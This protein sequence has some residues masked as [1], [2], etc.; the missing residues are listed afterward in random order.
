MAKRYD[1]IV[2]QMAKHLFVDKGMSQRD[3]TLHLRERYPEQC[4]RLS[5][6]MVGQWVREHHWKELRATLSIS[7][8]EALANA[9]K[10]FIAH[11]QDYLGLKETEPEKFRSDRNSYADF[12]NKMLKDIA[13]LQHMEADPILVYRSLAKVADHYA[14]KDSALAAQLMD[15][16]DAWIA[17]T[18]MTV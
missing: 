16:A 3:I 1:N 12:Q 17:E 11:Q 18:K 15:I 14:P 5:E 10:I 2:I 8:E 13:A 4:A 9:R 7:N 6:H